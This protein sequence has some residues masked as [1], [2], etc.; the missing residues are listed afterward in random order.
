MQ[1][2]FG[3][4]AEDYGRFRAGMPLAFFE[5]LAH[6]GIGMPRQR[7]LDLGTGTGAIARGFA[8]FPNEP[9]HIRHRVFAALGRAP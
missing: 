1:V 5:R 3:K 8:R 2:D 7:I 9:L 6:F 4:T